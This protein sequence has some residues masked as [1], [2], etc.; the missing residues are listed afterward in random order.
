M[1]DEKAFNRAIFAADESFG[2]ASGSSEWAEKLIKA[3]E[4]AKAPTP[5]LAKIREEIENNC[6]F[7]RE[8]GVL[9]IDKEDI[10]DIIT[11]HLEE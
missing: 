7:E 1:I 5:D 11:K 9:V 10:L 4:D 3:Y 6:W 8:L 2:N